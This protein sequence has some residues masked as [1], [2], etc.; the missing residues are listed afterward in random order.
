M[1]HRIFWLLLAAGLTVGC[2]KE[3]PSAEVLG[4]STDSMAPASPRGP[5]SPI[6][7][8]PTNA[9]VIVDTGDVNATVQQLTQELRDYVVSSRS[10]PKNFEEFAAKS[11][12]RFP[13]APSGKKYAIEGQ[14]V[15]LV[16]R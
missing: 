9:T 12:V 11:Q 7:E 16:K 4:A 2:K 6:V 3:Q 10:V 15:V 14:T 1:N 5:G 8:T 13:P